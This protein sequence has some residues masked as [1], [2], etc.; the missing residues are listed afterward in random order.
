MKKV[1]ILFIALQVAFLCRAWEPKE[2]QRGYRG[3][4]DWDNSIGKTYFDDSSMGELKHG[5]V[6][7]SGLSTSHGFQFNEHF[8]LGG[9]IMF[10]FPFVNEKY[11]SPVFAQF[12]YDATIH[13]FTPFGDIRMGYDFFNE[14]TG[15][16]F[17]PTV[18]YR[19][20]WGRR[21]NLNVGIGI[22][23]TAGESYDGH[24]GGLSNYKEVHVS[25]RSVFFAI[26]V[27]IDF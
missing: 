27:G 19:F 8:F 4:V 18:G 23:L 24:I 26:R 15:F 7:S 14:D 3:F 13:K 11:I 25:G 12:R 10:S 17:S 6:I 2:L 16:Y 9:G 1:V 20:N 21:T 22:T 5:T